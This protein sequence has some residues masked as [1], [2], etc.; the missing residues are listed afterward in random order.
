MA[1]IASFARTPIANFQGAFASVKAPQ[2]ASHAIKAALARANIDPNSS[3]VGEA[4]L[5]NVISAGIG[6]APT[7]Q[8]VLSSGLPN[9][10]PCTTINKVCAS[11]MKSAM[12][13]AQSILLGHQDIVLA[14]GFESM[15]NI[16][17]YLPSARAGFR[18]GNSAAIDGMVHDGLWDPYDDQHMGLCGEHCST[19]YSI[20]REEQDEYAIES[21]RRAKAAWDGGFFT[22]E[23][24]PVE[25]KSRKGAVIVDRDEEVDN[26]GLDKLGGL[27]PAFKR[28]GSVTAGNSSKISDGAAAMVVMSE[29]VAKERGV[30]PIAKILG[31]GDAAHEPINFTT[32]PAKAVANALKNAGLQQQD[33]EYHEINEAF[34]VVALVNMKLMNLDPA[35]VN[36]HGGAVALGHPIG[37]SGA[38]LVG[39][40]HNVLQRNDATIGCASIC[41]GGGGASAIIVERLD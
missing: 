6:Q 19:E 32:A 34:A 7:K 27:R 37:M 10:I 14:G 17:Y 3:D 23:V 40:L 8:A 11:G 38:R 28:D 16:P 41:N 18:M 33:L 31:F 12:F 29:A 2:L 36:V 35:R 1:V 5:G 20:S 24:V 21:Y 15:T 9:T 13:A 39:A 30:K 4:F 22:Q 25:V 26:T